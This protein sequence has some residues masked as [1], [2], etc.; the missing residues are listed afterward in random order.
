MESVLL[1]LTL[2]ALVKA[3]LS[4]S[5][6][7]RRWQRLTFG[8]LYA[9]SLW[10]FRPYALE[11]NKLQVE[12]ALSE[13]QAL[14]N[15]SL[16]V[17]LD[18]LVTCAACRACLAPQRA[19]RRLRYLP[20][21]LLF[22]ALFYVQVDLFF[23]CTG[24]AFTTLTL[25]LSIGIFVLLSG[26]G[27]LWRRWFPSDESRIEPTLLCGVLIFALTGLS[28]GDVATMAYNMQV[29]FATT[30]IGLFAGAVGFVLLQI[31]QRWAARDLASLDYL[32]ALA[33]ERRRP[34]AN[35]HPTPPQA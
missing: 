1:L 11:F 16:V 12:S 9:A 18:L 31:E 34:D 4:G 6:L 13:P 3:T 17:M 19:L 10:I 14:T 29:A 20:S 8:A 32:S 7:P 27:Y 23:T 26:G 15:L 30:V 2:L 35:A 24:Q 5:L 33:L 21:L 28:T 25:W 22:P